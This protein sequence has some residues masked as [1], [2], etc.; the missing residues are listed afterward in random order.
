MKT[1]CNLQARTQLS[2][3]DERKVNQVCNYLLQLLGD[4]EDKHE[5][6]CLLALEEKRYSDCKQIALRHPRSDYMRALSCIASAY[7]SPSV[8]DSII[9]YASQHTYN[10]LL[11]RAAS[12]IEMKINAEFEKIFAE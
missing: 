7:R 12:N 1:D 9:A 4:S 11:S 8:S 3:L 2:G 5:R 6:E 10:V